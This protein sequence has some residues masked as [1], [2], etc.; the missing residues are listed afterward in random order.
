MESAHMGRAKISAKARKK[1]HIPWKK[2]TFMNEIHSAASFHIQPKNPTQQYLLDC[3]ENYAI[4]VAIGPAGTGKT[5]CSA[6]KVSQLYLKGGYDKIVLSRVNIPT[7]RSLGFFPGTVQEKMAPW[8]MPLTD[9]L[10]KGLGAGRYTH[11]ENKGE[12]EVQPIETIR[13]RSYE[14]TL[15]L[16]DESQNLTIEEIK[17]IS[18]RLGE[19]SKLVLLGDPNQSDVNSGE[20]LVQFVEMCAK[21]NIEIPICRFGINDIVRSDIVSQLVKMFYKESL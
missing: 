1:D 11:M 8:L 13:G 20:G 19:G 2:E 15:V 9:V 5:Y 10:K 18:T 4:T 7:G 21:Y 14:N 17:A 6:M 3:I 12:I 16:V